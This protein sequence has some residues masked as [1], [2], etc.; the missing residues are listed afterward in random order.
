MRYLIVLWL[1]LLI[2]PAHAQ[3]VVALSWE[4]AEYLLNLGIE[5][6]AVADLK[7]YRLW[8]V[9]PALSSRVRPV[10]SRLEPNLELLWRLRPD[11]IVANTSLQSA[12]PLLQDIAPT[13]MLD[14]FRSDHDNTVAAERLQYQLAQRLGRLA[15]HRQFMRQQAGHY[16]QLR[17]RLH[18]HFGQRLPHVCVLRFA[19]PASYWAYGDNSAPQAVMQQLGLRNA[20]PQPV[21]VWGAQLR[22]LPQLQQVGDHPV[23]H[24]P[25]FGH[26]QQLQRSPLWQSFGFVRQRRFIALPAV[27][28][29]GGLASNLRLAQ[30]MVD[31]LVRELPGHAGR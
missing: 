28:T 4:T 10:G 18:Q 12:L 19:T 23:L 26:Y 1:S 13:V 5:P 14:P 15:Q 16:Q 17:Q 25:P 2:A 30:A 21:S 8:V 24:I 7:D 31:A 6:I 29:H 20:C 9:Q 11:L 3:R 27:W 22:Q